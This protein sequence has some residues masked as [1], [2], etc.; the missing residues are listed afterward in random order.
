MER[1]E[2]IKTEHFQP[3][4]E[5]MDVQEVFRGYGL[6]VNAGVVA[7]KRLLA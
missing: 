1:L 3:D 7:S 4:T 2:I 6:A 5:S